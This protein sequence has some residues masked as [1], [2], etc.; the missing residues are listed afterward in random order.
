MCLRPRQ[1]P[2]TEQATHT[3]TVLDQPATQPLK[4]D[5]QYTT[6]DRSLLTKIIWLTHEFCVDNPLDTK[7]QRP[8]RVLKSPKKYNA[9]SGKW[10]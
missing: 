2:Q 7:P 4:T 5:R 9:A 3:A 6:S 10:E 8:Q 1:P